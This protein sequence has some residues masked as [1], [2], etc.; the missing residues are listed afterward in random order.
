M[1]RVMCD[2]CKQKPAVRKVVTFNKE[3]K[4]V[5]YLCEDCYFERQQN[6][7]ISIMHGIANQTAGTASSETAY[8][9]ENVCRKCGT[10][11]GEFLRTGILGCDN[12]YTD[13]A[14]EI[15]AM[16]KS[17]QGNAAHTGKSPTQT[18][19][20]KAGV[21]V[22]KEKASENR[23]ESVPEENEILKLKKQLEGAILTEDFE[24][25]CVLRDKINALEAEDNGNA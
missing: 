23:L 6:A 19:Q 14:P 25:A 3:N 20:K 17:S 9:R 5:S 21:T 11:A 1:Y 16:I 10:T 13:L 7:K 18:A 12:C 15:L 2:I 4:K 24:Q 8:A 22:R